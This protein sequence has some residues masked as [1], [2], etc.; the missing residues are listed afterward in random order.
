[1]T[2]VKIKWITG[3]LTGMVSDVDI[4]RAKREIRDKKAEYYDKPETVE[5]TKKPKK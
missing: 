1:M 3:E 4:D 5:Q 2:Q